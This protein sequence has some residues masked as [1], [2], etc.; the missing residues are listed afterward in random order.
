MPR[1]PAERRVLAVL[2]LLVAGCAGA[3]EL[4]TLF[5]TAEERARLDRL[6]RGESPAAAATGTGSRVREVTGFV[7]RSDGRG[8]VWIDGVPVPVAS[9]RAGPLFDPKSVRGYSDRHDAEL[10]IERKAPR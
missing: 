2:L 9:P 10:R 7:Q 4:G 6:R 5:N 1:A 8:T 3:A